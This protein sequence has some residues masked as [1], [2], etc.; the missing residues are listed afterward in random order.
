MKSCL[1]AINA[2]SL[3]D[4]RFA[5]WTPP[6][7]RRQTATFRPPSAEG[8]GSKRAMSPP[9]NSG[10]AQNSAMGWKVTR[11]DIG[12][13]SAPDSITR[14]GDVEEGMGGLRLEGGAHSPG[15]TITLP[16]LRR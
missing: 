4:E 1:T 11:T 7:L 6:P 5:Y 8:H 10:S 15:G 9:Q 12:T 16:L 2:Y 3:I 13:S 14:Q